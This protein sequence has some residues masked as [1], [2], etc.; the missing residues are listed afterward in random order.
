[1][2][3]VMSDIHGEYEKYIRMIKEID[4]RDEDILYVIGDVVDRG[5]EPIKILQ[6]MMNRT[7][8]YPLMGNHDLVALGLLPQLNEELTNNDGKFGENLALAL[9]VWC[10]DGGLSTITGFCDLGEED[11]EDII[12]YLRE[13]TLLEVAETEDKSFVLVHA[14]LGNY[15]PGKKLS[16]YTDDDLLFTR[17][18]PSEQYFDDEGVY[19]VMGHTPTPFF[20]GK[21]EIYKNGR[22]IFIDCGACS[23]EG[24]LACLCLET[25]EEFYI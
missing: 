7:N 6:D 11:R 18:D 25:M 1:M 21:P 3:Y 19:V 5:P 16:E 14:G 20:T 24:K 12:E 22:N 8:V 15:R 13:F 17:P 2:T 10:D 4:L 9:Q 23:P